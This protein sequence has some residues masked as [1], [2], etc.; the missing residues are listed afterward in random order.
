MSQLS[1]DPL[2][3]ALL[4]DLDDTLCDY[5]AAREARLRIAFSLDADGA[6][7]ARADDVLQ[8]MVAESI[9]IHPHGTDHFGELLARFGID[10]PDV[11]LAGARW[12]RTN[13]FHGLNLFQGAEDVLRA[14]RPSSKTPGETRPVG[15][16]TN[17]PSEVQRAKLDLLGING[18]VDFVLISE[19]IG[20]A[21]PDPRIFAE[22]LSRAGVGPEEAVFIGDTAEHDILGA[23]STGISTIWINR[24]ADVWP[25]PGRAPDRVVRHI[26]EVPALVGSGK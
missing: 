3:R 6:S 26:C 5:S 16:I 2:P 8:R 13:R 22:A 4:F 11:A 12:Y 20:V 1:F 21:K 19:E 24:E 18:L 10:D 23:Q 7:I 17:G 15:I 14:V 9:A 25:G